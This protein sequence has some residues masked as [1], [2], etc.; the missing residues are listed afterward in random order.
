MN[1][2][3]P[4]RL[5]YSKVAMYKDSPHHYWC[6]LT[7]EPIMQASAFAFGAAFEA[8]V[9]AL[10]EG[11][12]LEEASQIFETEWHTRPANKWE[13]ERQI[14]DSQTIFFY[15][16]DYER[17][18]LEKE[19]LK[20]ID[21]WFLE[22]VKDVKADSLEYAE[23]LFDRIKNNEK[24][25]DN[26]R[27]FMNRVFWISCKKRGPLMLK[28]FKEQ[29]MPEIEEVI[30]AQKP[31][32]LE[33][34]DGNVIT[35]YID[36]IVKLKGHSKPIIMDLKS[37]GRPYDQHQLIS[38]DQLGIYALA[39]DLNTVGYWVVLKKVTFETS[40]DKCGHLRTNSRKTKC[41]SCETGKYTVK[42]PKVGTQ[43]L[44]HEITAKRLEIIA[45]DYSEVMTA[46]A[47]G[48]DWRNPKACVAYNTHCD[49]Y[50]NCINGKDLDDI[51]TLRRRTRKE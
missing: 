3:T 24:L 47:N 40:C 9:T 49:F 8:G 10:L 23:N 19:D 11:K 29:L 20:Q 4:I 13:D 43:T 21:K 2:K 38:S 30:A 27:I 12:T 6:S 39:E 36:Y 37:A 18:I 50:E 5:S 48:L 16:S 44:I 41:E 14:F 7:H 15:Q 42:T 51:P 22:L 25:S 17:D 31:I 45:K 46:V 26:D 1:N 35:G 28:A 32:A 34:E 33:T